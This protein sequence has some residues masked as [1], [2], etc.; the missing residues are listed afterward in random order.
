MPAVAP[1][2]PPTAEWGTVIRSRVFGS[3]F[4]PFNE[5]RFRVSCEKN[6]RPTTEADGTGPIPY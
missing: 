5:R 1:L 6:A 2:T 3:A 4:S